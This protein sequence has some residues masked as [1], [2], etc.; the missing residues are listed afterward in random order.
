M[1][2]KSV[3]AVIDGEGEHLFWASEERAQELVRSGEATP[4]RRRGVGR[5]LVVRE[6]RRNDAAAMRGR[7]TGF[8]HQRYSHDHETED[9]P[10]GVWTFVHLAAEPAA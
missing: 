2:T 7:G 8:D 1:N 6:D 4:I 10:R 5:I 9:N 3:I